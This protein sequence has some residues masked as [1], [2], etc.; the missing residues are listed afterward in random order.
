MGLE[1][2]DTFK[3]F[4]TM[5]QRPPRLPSSRN[6]CFT[7]NNYKQQDVDILLGSKEYKYILIGRETGH[8]GTPHLQCYVQWRLRK[9]LTGVKKVH[10]T[11][12]WEI[13]KGSYEQ[14]REYCTKGNDWEERGEPTIN[15]KHTKANLAD[16][17][18]DLHKHHL[19]NEEMLIKYGGGYVQNKRKVQE[20]AKDLKQDFMRMLKWEK[21]HNMDL[22][23]W[24][25]EFW[26]IFYEAQDE[27]PGNSRWV[28]WVYSE[29]GKV[30]K[31][32]MANYI[33]YT[34]TAFVTENSKTADIKYAY[35][36]E[37]VVVFDFV[38]SSLDHINYEIIEILKN[39]RFINTK[40]ESR[41]FEFYVPRIVCFA[42]EPPDMTK[43]SEDRWRIYK[44]VNGKKLMREYPPPIPPVA[45]IFRLRTPPAARRRLFDRTPGAPPTAQAGPSAT[46][47]DPDPLGQVLSDLGIIPSDDDS[48]MWDSTQDPAYPTPGQ[49]PQQSPP[50]NGQRVTFDESLDM[51][52][53]S[54]DDRDLFDSTPPDHVPSGDEVFW[55]SDEPGM[56]AGVPQNIMGLPLDELDD[57]WESDVGMPVD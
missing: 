27:D 41:D 31:S 42:N 19:S 17:V 2:V 36:G 18:F 22:N 43:L 32:W 3:L 56:V 38:R 16:A 10:S 4:Y 20:C 7:V 11:A 54:S 51:I 49:A 13:A 48:I 12:H 28:F 53:I 57:I 46:P 33:K 1:T 8:G 39:G 15:G 30:G 50:D 23:E 45:E 55:S 6:W 24:Q 25:R 26:Q 35:D 37:H 34:Q 44:I 5:A 9:M 47:A 21:F 14:N 29:E 52:Q 40:Y